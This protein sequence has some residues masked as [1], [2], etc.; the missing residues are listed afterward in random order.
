[1]LQPPGFEDFSSP[2]QVC[3]LH[4]SLYGLKQ[5]PRAWFSTFSQYLV[6][7][8][9][10]HGKSDSSLFIPRTATSVT[11]LLVY[12]DDILITGDSSSHIQSLITKM[13]NVFSMKELGD[14][15]YFLGISDQPTSSGYLLSQSKYAKE[16][17]LK[18]G[19]SSCEPRPSPIAVKPSVLPNASLPFSDPALYRSIVGALQYLT[20]TRPD[21]S[22]SVNQACQHMHAPTI[23]HFAAIKRIL[24]YV[25]GTITH[26]LFFS[27]STFDV[28]GYSNSNWAGDVH[29]RKS[30]SGYCVFL[31]SN[32]VSWSAKK[33]VTVSRSSTEAEYR[34]LANTAAE[35]SWIS[36]LLTE[37]GITS[38]TTPILCV[39]RFQYLKSKLMVLDRPISLP[40]NI[41]D[42]KLKQNSSSTASTDSVTTNAA[43]DS[44]IA[45]TPAIDSINAATDSVIAATPTTESVISATL[46]RFPKPLPSQLY[47]G[48]YHPVVT[49]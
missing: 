8:G 36:M 35:L 21:L 16:I 23:E 40:R 24:R 9:F 45:A 15:A 33:Q 44:V 29:D 49:T 28:H 6:S 20:I 43:T 22:L 27:S 14:I 4:K 19:L 38:P 7:Q 25:Q 1:M 13:H 12:V 26:G 39:S 18:A 30:T 5:A 37:M 48:H 11:Y 2:H 34:A 17:L 47:S 41:E 42:P 31:G 3:K 10:T 46:R 32:L